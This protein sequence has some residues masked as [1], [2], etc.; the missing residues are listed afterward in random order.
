MQPAQPV[1]EAGWEDYADE[2]E[3]M[4][5]MSDNGPRRPDGKPSVPS[6]PKNPWS[7]RED[8]VKVLHD[9]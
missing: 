4:S 6:L 5:I 9:R 7:A 1:A 3:K 2:D 8:D